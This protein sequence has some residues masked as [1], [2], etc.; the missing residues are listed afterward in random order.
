MSKVLVTGCA[1]LLGN[2]FTRYLLNQGHDVFG[3]DN[4]SGGY[5]EYIDNR[6]IQSEKRDVRFSYIDLLDNEGL[7]NVFDYFKPNYVYHFAAYAALGL[8]P[9]IRN[10]NYYNNIIASVNLINE[11]IKFDVKKFIFASSMDVYGNQQT[12][13]TEDMIPKPEDPYGIAKFAIEMDLVNAWE[14]FGLNYSIVRPH[15]IIGI[16]Q[17]IWDRYRNVVGIWIRRILNKEPILIYG[18]GKQRRAFS[19]VKYY[20]KP[21]E[22]LMTLGDKE[23]FNIGADKDVS[24]LDVALIVQEIAHELGFSPEI[25]Y[26]EARFEVEIAHC[27]HSKSKTIL[28]FNDNTNLHLLINEMFHWAMKQPKREVRNFKYEIDKNLYNYWK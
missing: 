10:F 13:F 6:L 3:V 1:G 27:D 20:M 11:C 19:D 9:F 26:E 22:Q 4:L 8:S 18:D 2:H 25:Q 21:F 14:Q 15:N 23:I 5:M 24:I 28:D 16:Y 12:P 17:N 7:N